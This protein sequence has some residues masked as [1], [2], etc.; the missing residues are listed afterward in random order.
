MDEENEATDSRGHEQRT[1][2]YVKLFMETR[3]QV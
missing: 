3:G 2:T 1:V